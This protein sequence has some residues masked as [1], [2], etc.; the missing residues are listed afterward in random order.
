MRVLIPDA[1]NP[2]PSFIR[3]LIKILGE[4]GVTVDLTAP[5]Q[6]G[7]VMAKLRHR[8]LVPAESSFR[9]AIAQA[10]V[11]HFQ[12]PPTYL[13]LGALARRSGTPV[14]LSLRG[15][16]TNIV[17]HLPGQEEYRRSLTEQLPACDA[18]HCVSADVRD[19]AIPLGLVPDRAHV[20]RP[21]IDVHRFSP[22]PLADAAHLRI[23]MVGGLMWRKGYEYALT[24]LAGLRDAG[25]P[26]HLTIAGEGPDRERIEWTATDLGLADQVTLLG[27]VDHQRIVELLQ[28]SDVLLHTSLSEGIANSVL[29]A[30]GCEVPV[31]VWDAGGM[32][33]AVTDGVEGRLV[34]ARDLDATWRA[35]ASVHDDAATTRRMAE[36]GRRRVE[37]DF[38]LR[39]RAKQFLHLYEAALGNGRS[40]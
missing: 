25:Y 26:F 33:E 19:R 3:N 34:P 7:R 27:A 37:E 9:R 14:V 40:R 38:D 31:V 11:V 35:I 21:A 30:M 39:S 10:D 20:I 8:G 5:P 17:P 13:N 23:V 6:H 2:P 36:A 4:H 32:S 28:Q 18:Y 16:L 12:W 15:R 29:E 1:G 22:V 24:S